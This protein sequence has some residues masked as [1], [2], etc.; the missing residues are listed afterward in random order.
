[1]R[2]GTVRFK[3]LGNNCWLPARFLGGVCDRHAKCE[4]PEKA[5]CKATAPE[6]KKRRT[7]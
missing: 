5:D 2:S 1:M 7:K 3:Q 4:Y 6:T